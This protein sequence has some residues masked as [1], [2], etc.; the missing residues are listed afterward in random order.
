MFI[1]GTRKSGV[2]IRGASRLQS[3]ELDTEPLGCVLRLAQKNGAD[4]VVGIHPESP[5]ARRHE[6]I[7]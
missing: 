5:P 3:L 4:R 6:E 1:C 2:N 7:R